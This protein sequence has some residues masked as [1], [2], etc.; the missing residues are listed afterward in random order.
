MAALWKSIWTNDTILKSD[1][2]QLTENS[3]TDL[4]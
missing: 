4:N 3:K 1:L 2:N